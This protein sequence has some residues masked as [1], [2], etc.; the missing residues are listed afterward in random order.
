MSHQVQ[1]DPSR[2]IGDTDRA[3]TLKILRI[4]SGLSQAEVMAHMGKSQ[5]FLSLI[6]RGLR[7]PSEEEAQI[8]RD[9]IIQALELKAAKFT[10]AAKK[11]RG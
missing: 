7:A 8:I 9:A 10:E 5:M 6:E 11:L 2:D 1:R 3:R 4:D